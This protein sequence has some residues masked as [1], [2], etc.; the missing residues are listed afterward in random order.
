VTEP[1][2]GEVETMADKR[3]SLVSGCTWRSVPFWAR[4]LARSGRLSG[5]GWL[6]CPRPFSIFLKLIFPFSILNQKMIWLAIK[7]HKLE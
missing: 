2:S 4:R 3:A 6:A 1:V 5:L 7:M